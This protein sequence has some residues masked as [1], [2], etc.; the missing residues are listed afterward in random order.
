MCTARPCALRVRCMFS[1]GALHEL[2]VAHCAARA[3]KRRHKPPATPTCACIDLCPHLAVARLATATR[4]AAA[5]RAL[6]RRAS[7]RPPPPQG[8]A[9]TESP[10]TFGGP[11]GG[12]NVLISRI[13]ESGG[14]G[15]GI[16]CGAVTGGGGGGG[17]GMQRRRHPWRAR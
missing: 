8:F 16:C 1:A 15:G 3:A 6:V 10:Q 12:A 2:R 17:S 11:F 14:G 4:F 7:A 13:A 9:R 5:H